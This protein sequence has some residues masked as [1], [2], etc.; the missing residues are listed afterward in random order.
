MIN[1][2]AWAF[3]KMTSTKAD[4]S[5]AP[6]ARDSGLLTLSPFV[7]LLVCYAPALYDLVIDWWQDPN[8]SH[9]FLVPMVS[10]YLLHC[11]R[12]DLFK[13]VR[14]NAT[15]GLLLIICGMVLFVVANGA[16]EYFT[17]RFSFVLSLI[18]L[19]WYLFGRDMIRRA[20]FELSFLVFMIPI[21]YVIYYAVTFPMQLLA[22]KITVVV[23]N[24]MGAGAVRQGNVI[25]LAGT[26]LE[27]AEAC[28]GMRSLISLLA[29]GALYA[30][31]S[32]LKKTGKWILFISTIPIAI[33]ANVARVLVTSML[34]YLGGIDVVSEPAHSIL[35]MI[36]FIFAFVVLF[37][38]SAILRRLLR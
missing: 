7:L 20:W 28:S 10:A 11:K 21:P 13:V 35:G 31:L 30:Y 5:I 3:N 22:S 32:N 23:L 37:V 12:D 33:L 1:F 34:A 9:G 29:L 38:E 18:G 15:A 6:T 2:N 26:V 16:A 4:N 24:L 36:V 14:S 17:I 27:V 25:H 19:I 8:Y